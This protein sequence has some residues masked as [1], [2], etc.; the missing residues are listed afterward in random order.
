MDRVLCTADCGRNVMSREDT[1]FLS[2]S[3][4][5]T[6]SQPIKASTSMFC[7]AFGDCQNGHQTRNSR[8]QTG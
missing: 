1:I 7:F 6:L 8:A 2:T 4:S 3:A 5:H